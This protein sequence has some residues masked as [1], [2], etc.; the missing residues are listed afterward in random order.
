MNEDRA[1]VFLDVMVEMSVRL[2]F[3]EDISKLR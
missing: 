3:L 1:A 2:L